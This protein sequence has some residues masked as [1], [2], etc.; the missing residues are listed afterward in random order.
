MRRDGQMEEC[1]LH[2]SQSF[3]NELQVLHSWK[4]CSSGS[5]TSRTRRKLLKDFSNQ[6]KRQ[7]TKS[8]IFKKH[9]KK[10]KYHHILKRN[11]RAKVKVFRRPTVLT[12]FISGSGMKL[13]LNSN[14]GQ[15]CFGGAFYQ[16]REIV[17]KPR[18]FLLIQRAAL[19]FQEWI[20]PR[21]FVK[22][23]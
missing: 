3:A 6:P 11:N 5:L 22:A 18:C 9:L 15:T 4:L 14:L 8:A 16:C 20:S 23:C 7:V 21:L 19:L 2:K 17:V 12:L 13:L 10:K 1:P